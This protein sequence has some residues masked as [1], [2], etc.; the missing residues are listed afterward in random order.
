MRGN[1]QR[2]LIYLSDDH[3][4]HEIRAEDEGHV[5]FLDILAPPY[6][7]ETE[8]EPLD[9]DQEELRECNF[10][11]EIA[12]PTGSSKAPQQQPPVT[13]NNIH[14]ESNIVKRSSTH[15]LRRVKS[16]DDY[17]CDT[18]PYLGQRFTPL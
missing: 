13:N 5:A 1:F 7:A 8:V 16:P 2:L 10:F 9:D 4:F 12:I 6:H 18:E 14:S 3:N 15:W 11:C 17:F